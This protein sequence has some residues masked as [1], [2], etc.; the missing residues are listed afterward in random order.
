LTTASRESG[1]TTEVT[2]TY[3]YD[4][5]ALQ[6]VDER[7][8]PVVIDPPTSFRYVPDVL[9]PPP[10]SATIE[11]S[12]APRE[13]APFVMN[14]AQGQRLEL[15][16]ESP[17]GSVI[18]SVQG[19]S[20]DTQLVS[21]AAYATSLLM[22]LPA[23][24]AYSVNV[25]SVSGTPIDATLTYSLSPEQ[26][27]AGQ[28]PLPVTPPETVQDLAL[29][30]PRSSQTSLAGRGQP[31]AALSSEAQAFFQQRAPS[32]GIAVVTARD[33]LLYSE[34]GDEQL[35]TA[36]VIKVVVMTCVMARAEQQ[37]RHVNEWEL[38]LMWPMITYSDNDATDAL[39]SDLGG[40]PGVATCLRELGVT[41]ITPYN[42]PYWGTSTASATGMATLMSRLAFGEIV[43]PVHRGVAL[44][45]LVSVA[46]EQRWGI[47]A[48]ADDSGQEIV[49][50]KDGWYPDDDGWR[51][52]SVGF[53]SPIEAG[54]EPYAIAVMTN[55]QATQEYGIET[56]EGMARP[57]YVSLRE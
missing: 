18:L 24:Q 44:A 12:L 20:D 21:R 7:S 41:G 4:D 10:A 2:R 52:N 3:S 45:L 17:F 36:S 9:E 46:P 19:L 49:G 48:G 34:N 23:T 5:G 42:G 13:T 43:N 33:G 8:Q 16:V 25:T 35:E 6:L 32:R 38:S 51:V 30:V 55:Y 27:T 1:E 54:Q 29:A 47:P 50:V 40:G 31:L 53:I 11:R 15:R 14:G 57:L 28:P 39:W 37:G 56:I 26:A 22:D